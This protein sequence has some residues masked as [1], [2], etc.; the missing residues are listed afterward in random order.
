VNTRS[1]SVAGQLL[2]EPGADFAM[3]FATVR[4]ASAGAPS[5]EGH[6]A[7]RRDQERP[8]SFND[9]APSA[10]GHEALDRQVF[11]I[12]RASLHAAFFCAA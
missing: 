1:T 11:N 9:R 5:A 8:S 10:N 2:Y 6:E 3:V 7:Y 4:E 12:A